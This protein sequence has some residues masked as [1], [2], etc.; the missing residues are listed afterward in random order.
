MR[1]TIVIGID[2]ACW[3]YID[4]LLKEKKLPN[5]K[6]LIY[7]GSH[8]ILE[9]TL[10]PISPVAWSSLITGTN[11]GK[12][13]IFGWTKPDRKGSQEPVNST[14]GKVP[15]LWR[16]LNED[17]LKVGVFNVPVTYPVE[18]INGYIIPG[19]EAPTNNEDCVYPKN[20]YEIIKERYGD[21]F[22]KLPLKLLSDFKALAELGIESYFEKYCFSEEMRTKLALD[23]SQDCDVVL[24]NYMITDHLN[25]QLREFEFVK[26]AYCFVDR[27]IGRWLKRFPEENYIIVSDHGSTRIKG[28]INLNQLFFNKGFLQLKKREIDSLSRKEVNEILHLILRSGKLRTTILEK[29]IR[30][31]YL[32][33]L[34]LIPEKHR[35]NKLKRLS[36]A[37]PKDV[38]CFLYL[39]KIDYEKTIVHV[40]TDDGFIFLN[41]KY[42]EQKERNDNEYYKHVMKELMSFEDPF[43]DKPFFSFIYKTEDLFEGEQLKYAPE[44]YGDFWESA[45]F[46]NTRIDYNVFKSTNICRTICN[47]EDIGVYGSHQRNGIYIMF[48]PDIK[49]DS[50][51][52]GKMYSFLGVTPTVLYLQKVAIPEDFDGKIMKDALA[53][54]YIRYNKIE[55]R[56]DV[57]YSTKAGKSEVRAEDKQQIIEKLRRLAYID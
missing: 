46:V 10:P 36:R 54:E 1:K 34:Y 50:R 2:G 52:S 14:T 57:E 35:I 48:G 43:N 29:I 4:P 24:F 45:C 5:I 3:E 55:H 20:L 47:H 26:K 6:K 30:R 16:Y 9:S 39:D 13:G 23:L 27:M 7:N 51:K 31:I 32:L 12:H 17:G 49:N 11:P 53:P 28:I 19:F 15:P 22:N 44:L 21:F 18:E 37:A 8:G 41:K 33:Y 38:N 40:N 42:L 56:T 25:H